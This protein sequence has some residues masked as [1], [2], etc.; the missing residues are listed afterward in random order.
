MRNLWHSLQQIRKYPSAIFGLIIIA[1][2]VML[3]LYTI[4]TVPY[5]EAIRLWRGG[6]DV[7]GENPRLAAPAWY[8]LFSRQK[9]PVTM[10]LNSRDGAATKTVAASPTSADSEDITLL[11]TFDY[12]YDGFPQELVVVLEA[13]YAQ[14]PPHASLFWRTPD[15]REIRLGEFPVRR[16]ETYRLALDSRLT[17]RLRSDRPEVALFAD[18]NAD[19]LTPLKGTYELEVHV[20]TFEAD[21][22]VEAKWVAYGQLHGLAGTDHRRRDLM[23]ALMWGTPIALSF[24]LLA[25]F[26]TTLTTMFIAAV[27]VWFGG[28]VDG[29][30]QRITEVNMILPILPILIMIGTFY[31]QGRSIWVILGAVIALSIFGGA[32]KTFRAIFLQVKEAPYIEAARAYGASS[33][34]IITL[35]LIPRIL[36]VMIP[37][38]VSGVPV[39]VFLEASLALLG[40]GDPVLPT[41]GKLIDNARAQGALHNG[42]YYWVLQPAVLLMIVGLAFAMV[43]FSLDRI[44]N[45]RLRGL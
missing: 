19:S 30:I 43:G 31:P 28:W 38:L 14:K 36:P 27:G 21:T 9:Q 15:D 41:W 33:G 45:P 37:S 24:G 39:Y 2:M 20:H 11:F 29:I 16:S 6:E 17:R 4:A 25:A 7:W 42:Q 8:N 40:L 26:G 13:A 34:R 23:V 3:A 18:P 44:L 12:G 35:Y 32:I 22:D 1:A 5:R 10:V